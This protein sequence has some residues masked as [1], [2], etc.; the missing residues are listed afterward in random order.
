[1][2]LCE[3]ADFPD[4]IRAAASH[5]A[6]RGLTEEFIE[7]DYYVT[8][9]LR[10]VAAL[11]PT[12][13]VFKGGTSLSKGW[14]L[15]ERFSEDIDLFVNRELLPAS[16]SPKTAMKTV[17][18]EV[19]NFPNLQFLD[20]GQ[21][22]DRTPSRSRSDT[23]KSRTSDFQYNRLFNGNLPNRILLEMGIRSGDFPTDRV[24]ISSYVADFL[25]ETGQS[26]N[27]EDESPFEMTLLH[28]RRTFVEKLFAIHNNVE[29][30]LRNG[31]SLGK[32]ARHYYDLFCLLQR[33]EVLEML[34]NEKFSTIRQDVDRISRK[35]FGRSH[36]PPN[37][38]CFGQ[39]RALFPDTPELRKNIANTY[40]EQ[41][42][43]LCFGEFPA[44]DE[45]AAQ[46]EAV[47]DRL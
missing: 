20:F 35:Y 12:Q 6:G 39:S 15:I 24:R 10:V 22:I 31:E 32:Y 27:A 38:L 19:G 9:A 26:L 41:C 25:R 47:R 29:E 44:W 40:T 13:F 11:Y 3:S 4:V 18:T 16:I 46:F 2:K 34:G 14:N 7:K 1:M 42:K 45:V 21:T 28:F 33:S 8:E 23:N 36:F 30:S 43:T 17:Q 5:F 37:D